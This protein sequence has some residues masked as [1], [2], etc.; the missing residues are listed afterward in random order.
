MVPE[1]GVEVSKPSIRVVV[2]QHDFPKCYRLGPEGPPAYEEGGAEREQQV[3]GA[4]VWG[5]MPKVS[6][7]HATREMRG[8]AGE[9]AS[10]YDHLG[11]VSVD[12]KTAR[13]YLD[14]EWAVAGSHV[15]EPTGPMM[16]PNAVADVMPLGGRQTLR[17]GCQAFSLGFNNP[18]RCRFTR[19]P[20]FVVGAFVRSRE[21]QRVASWSSMERVLLYFMSSNSRPS[22]HSF[23]CDS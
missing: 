6:T 19:A 18:L 20:I 23:D 9:S 7:A 17:R 10:M 22:R 4:G 21:S 13:S 3:H 16:G 8:P 1:G 15:I 5:P 14:S 2:R 11:G 12:P